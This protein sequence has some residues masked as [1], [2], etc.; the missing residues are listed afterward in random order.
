MAWTYR[1]KRTFGN[2][3][4]MTAVLFLAILLWGSVTVLLGVLEAGT[5][6]AGYERP[7]LLQKTD[8][9]VPGRER[10]GALGSAPA[11][12]TAAPAP[13]EPWPDQ[14]SRQTA[15][16]ERAV[17]R[18]LEDD[19]SLIEVFGAYQALSDRTV[20]EDTADPAYSVARLENGS[21]TFIG[22]GEAD[23]GEQ[24]AELKR[25]QTALDERDAALLY[26]QAPSKLEP[27]EDV[28]PYGLED[29]S[30]DCADR[31]MEALEEA[32]I[33]HIDLRQT[34]REAG[35]EWGDWFYQTDHHWGQ[36]AA[37][38]CFQ[39]LAQKL[40][41][42][43]QTVT[44]GRETE[45]RS[46]A[47]DPR[48]AD[49]DSYDKQTLP[50][51]FLG[52]QG[53]RVGASYAGA[54]DF[55]LW[56][57]KFPTLLH[58]AGA[59]GGDRYGDLTETVLFPQRVEERDF[60]GGNPYTYYAGGDYPFAQIT[61]YYNPQGPRVLLIRDSFSCAITPYLALACSQLTTLDPR[62]FTGDLLGTIDWVRPD[63]VVVLYSSGMVREE[64]YYRLLAQP[65]ASKGDALRWEGREIFGET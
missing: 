24:A 17:T 53:K 42:Y 21:L 19:H 34:L 10:A 46:I 63:V 27:G 58:Y 11:D 43:Q 35:G 30:N 22:Q 9:T 61:N 4:A 38:V 3:Y 12:L 40:T 23:P 50:D 6:C 54:D 32:E 5:A 41:D 25:L 51:F 64:T 29:P 13:A 60:Y 15:A 52:S 59:T 31:L 49:P 65:A 33:D 55:V 20:V 44:V 47:I 18:A 57:P 39:A 14:L 2:R 56:T 45:T 48:C 37:F 28:L 36:E 62:S 7:G 8:P 1:L 26:L 16:A